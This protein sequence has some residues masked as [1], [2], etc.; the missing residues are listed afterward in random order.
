MAEIHT[1][2]KTINPDLKLSIYS[3]GPHIL[4][5]HRVAQDWETW[6]ERGYLDM[7]N[8]SGYLYPEQNGDD[9]LAQL[10][11]KNP[12]PPNQSSQPQA[13]R[14]P[15]HLP[16]GVRTSHGKVKSAQQIGEILQAAKRADVDGAAFFTWSYLQPWLDEVVKD[17]SI[18]R[19][20]SAPK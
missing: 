19:F 16:W 15:S 14:F 8:I 10:E 7:I 1:A 2:L 17:G 20:I 9:Y 3:W 13:S 11:E 18:E 12:H 4:E 5:N 6:V